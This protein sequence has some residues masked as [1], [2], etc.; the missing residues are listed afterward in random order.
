MYQLHNFVNNSAPYINAAHLNEMDLGIAS[1][2]TYISTCSTAAGTA[3]KTVSI[4]DF[5]TD[6]MTA[7]PGVP[8]VLYVLFTNGS[9]SSTMTISINSGT[10]R[11]VRYRNG[12][13]GINSLTIASND[14]VAF[15]YNNG[16]YYL[17]G[18]ISAPAYTPPSY[19]GVSNGGTGRTTLSANAVLAGNGTSAVKLITTANGALYA[20]SANGAPTFGPLPVAQGGTGGTSAGA[21]R[22]G[23]G[24]RTGTSAPTSNTAGDIYIRYST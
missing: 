19:W 24:I 6:T 9:T 13:S 3:A 7:S 14:I 5:A 11:S 8:F 15:V 18:S 10:A 23:L 21:A 12:T 2:C 1:G 20:T 17:L 4:S 22:Q 16:A